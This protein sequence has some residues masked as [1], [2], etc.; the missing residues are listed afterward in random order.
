MAD[1][2]LLVMW[3]FKSVQGQ[4]ITVVMVCTGTGGH[5]S[6]KGDVNPKQTKGA[7]YDATGGE[8]DDRTMMQKVKDAITPGSDVGKHGSK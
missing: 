5:G 7:E 8:V 1:T 4:S 3:V 6:N 2:Q